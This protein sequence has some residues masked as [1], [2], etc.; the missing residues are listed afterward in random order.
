MDAPVLVG[1]WAKEAVEDELGT[2]RSVVDVGVD[3]DVD[4]DDKTEVKA[5]ELKTS[6]L[7]V[8][9]EK[10]L[11]SR[12]ELLIVADPLTDEKTGLETRTAD[13]TY[14]LA[15]FAS[16]EDLSTDEATAV[17]LATDT[18]VPTTPATVSVVLTTRLE[19]G[20]QNTAGV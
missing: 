5:S 11:E 12:D 20:F 18:V 9:I 2:M 8:E 17:D 10:E 4:V 15:T 19:T 1:V 16:A 7:K 6:V 13:E 3:L 14:V